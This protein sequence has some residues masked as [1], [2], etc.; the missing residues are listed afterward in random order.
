MEISL[1]AREHVCEVGVVLHQRK[2]ERVT[3][4]YRDALGRRSQRRQE[5]VVCSKGCKEKGEER[6]AGRPQGQ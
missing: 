2:A 4:S 1:E 5:A 3:G 6:N